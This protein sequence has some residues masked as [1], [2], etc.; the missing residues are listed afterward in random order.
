VI[1][2]VLEP[3]ALDRDLQSRHVREV[4]LAELARLMNLG[5]EDLLD[6]P[7]RGPPRLDPPL[8]RPQLAILELARLLTLKPLQQCLGLQTRIH[9]K[10]LTDPIPDLSERILP[11]PPIVRPRHFARQLPQ[12]LVLAAGLDVNGRHRRCDYL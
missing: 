7:L 11:G 2:Q 4:R 3:L 5:E 6:R 12:P 10:L 9:L 8:Q 1:D